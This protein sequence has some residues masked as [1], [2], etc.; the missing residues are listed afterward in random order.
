MV[1]RA[2]KLSPVFLL[3]LLNAVAALAIQARAQEAQ[4]DEENEGND[5][6]DRLTSTQIAAQDGGHITLQRGRPGDERTRQALAGQRSTKQWRVWRRVSQV[7]VG[8]GLDIESPADL[9]GLQD[10]TRANRGHRDAH[11]PFD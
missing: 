5:N 8:I 2:C 4:R 3:C 6:R 9:L 7:E 11:S 10:L 1:Q